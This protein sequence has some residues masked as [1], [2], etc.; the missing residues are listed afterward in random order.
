[1]NAEIIEEVS[2]GIPFGATSF[3]S[4]APGDQLTEGFPGAEP[5]KS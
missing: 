4:F 2:H 1:M 5:K 3:D